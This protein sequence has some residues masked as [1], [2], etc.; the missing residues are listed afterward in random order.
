MTGPSEAKSLAS[1]LWW[2]AG[3]GAVFVVQHAVLYAIGIRFETYPLYG[4]L[5]FLDPLL[6]KTRLIESCFYLHVQ[7]PLFNL[8]CGIVLKLAPG[9]SGGVFHLCYIFLGFSLCVSMFVLMARMGISHTRAFIL[10]VLFMTGPAFILYEN[11]LFYTLPCTLFMT[12]SALSLFGVIERGSIRAACVFFGCLLLLSGL[13]SIFHLVH[14]V[15]LFVTVVSL[16]RLNRRRVMVVGLIPMLLIVSLYAKN[17]VLFGSFGPSTLLGKNLYINTIGNMGWEERKR[18]AAEGVLSPLALINRW[19][20]LDCYPEEYQDALGFEGIPALHDITKSNGPHNFNHL[21]HI[22]ISNAYMKDS[23]AAI[24]HSPKSFALALAVSAYNY[25]RPSGDYSCSFEN[26]RKLEAWKS[27]RDCVLAGK[28]PIEALRHVG[29]GRV[30]GSP[31]YVFLLLG[32][33]LLFLY[34]LYCSWRGVSGRRPLST[35]QRCA[36]LYFCFNILYV[37]ALGVLFD[38]NETY[39]YRFTTDPFS[40]AIL[41]LFVQNVVGPWLRTKA[42]GAKARTESR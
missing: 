37:G 38:F 17:Y 41:G 18:L 9:S 5:H 20:A 31:P 8:F 24:K 15:I 2:I 32:L 27:W 23:I 12:V 10:T 21:A 29:P 33:P 11:W 39:R 25:F 16:C 13:W 28:L 34:S 40:L 3:L 19:N 30:T 22:R 4:Y 36:L 14:Y 7:P 35:S 26:S 6:L 1:P 42:V